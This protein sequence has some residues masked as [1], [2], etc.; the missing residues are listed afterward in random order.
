MKAPEST[1]FRNETYACDLR[2]APRAALRSSMSNLKRVM[3]R[4]STMVG[5]LLRTKSGQ[6]LRALLGLQPSLGIQV[7]LLAFGQQLGWCHSADS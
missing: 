7:V 3:S 1:C 6:S 2:Y 5:I 4:D